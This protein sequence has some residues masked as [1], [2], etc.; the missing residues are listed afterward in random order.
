[1]IRRRGRRGVAFRPTR[2]WADVS[3]Q[4]V[5][6]AVATTTPVALVQLQ[7]PSNLSNL[8]ADPPEDLTVLRVRGSFSVTIDSAAFAGSWSLALLV[9]DTA[10]TPSTLFTTDAD[11]R[12]LWSRDYEF[13]SSTSGNIVTWRPPGVFQDGVN[14]GAAFPCQSEQVTL[15]ISPKVKIEAGKALTLVAY[16]N[17]D[18]STLTVSSQNMRVLFQR[19]GRR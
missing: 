18:G 14:A 8:T 17:V 9:Q 10:W 16:E 12:I 7:A 19:S 3:A 6:T 15:D 2:V 13:T 1:M 11:K 4:F 5:F